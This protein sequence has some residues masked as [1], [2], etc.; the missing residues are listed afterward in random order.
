MRIHSLSVVTIIPIIDFDGIIAIVDSWI[1]AWVVVVLLQPPGPSHF[2]FTQVIMHRTGFSISTCSE[3]V[4]DYL[5]LCSDISAESRLNAIK[6]C[7]K[8][9]SG[10][11]SVV[12]NFIDNLLA[13][14]IG[15]SNFKV[16]TRSEGFFWSPDQLF[17]LSFRN[18]D[19][20]LDISCC[21]LFFAWSV[22]VLEVI[23]T[24][25]T[26]SVATEST[27]EMMRCTSVPHSDDCKV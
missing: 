2:K 15:F 5:C 25:D 18:G 3:V 19:W 24:Q 27:T 16:D 6:S 23:I 11:V 14:G 21:S 22:V 26:S 20:L 7:F 9:S 8:V 10:H 1:V 17:E 12:L 4:K 13:S